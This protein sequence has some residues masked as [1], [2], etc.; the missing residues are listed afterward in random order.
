MQYSSTRCIAIL[1]ACSFVNMCFSELFRKQGAEGHRGAE[2]FRAV[3][4]ADS[5]TV[6]VKTVSLS[7]DTEETKT[8]MEVVTTEFLSR[9]FL[10]D[11]PFLVASR[12]LYWEP[13]V[14]SP[15][16]FGGGVELQGFLVMDFA[17]GGPADL[18]LH[19]AEGLPWGSSH[20]SSASLFSAQET[21]AIA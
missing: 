19:G 3:R 12:G 15:A 8:V 16:G 1:L 7:Q 20:V 17:L 5:K 4:I 9:S 6:F 21:I 10:G 2:S 18:R 13:R 14:G 11:H